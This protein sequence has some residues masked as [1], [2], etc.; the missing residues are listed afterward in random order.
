[1]VANLHTI[2]P[3]INIP[4]GFTIQKA[5]SLGQIKKFGEALASLFGTSEEGQYVQA[6]YNQTASAHLWNSENMKLYLGFY[7]DEVVAVGSL[8]CTLD[9]IGIYDIANERRNERKRIWFYYV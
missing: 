4:E 7:K 8:V 5:S 9:S 3:T 2:L 6:F 1:M